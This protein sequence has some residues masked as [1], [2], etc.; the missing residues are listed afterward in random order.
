[1]IAGVANA[2]DFLGSW[3]GSSTLS[4]LGRVQQLCNGQ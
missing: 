2:N 3:N 4:G 1:V